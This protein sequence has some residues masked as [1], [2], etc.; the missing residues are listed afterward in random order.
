MQYLWTWLNTP[1]AFPDVLDPF[2]LAFAAVFTLGFLASAYLAGPAG[3]TLARADR[4]ANVIRH[5]STV[6]LWL[7]GPGLFFLAIRLLQINP[8][9]FGEPIWLVGCVIALLVAALRFAAWRRQIGPTLPERPIEPV[10]FRR[11]RN[12][13]AQ[14]SAVPWNRDDSWESSLRSE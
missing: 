12:L 2:A 5:W 11:R 14:D 13:G 3:E 7:F 6:G 8:L 4:E 1:P 10:S 9:S